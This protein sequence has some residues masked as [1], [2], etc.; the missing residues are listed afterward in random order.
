MNRPDLF[1]IW[2]TGLVPRISSPRSRPLD[3]DGSDLKSSSL[4]LITPRQVMSVS[5]VDEHVNPLL[6]FATSPSIE[7][8]R[9]SVGPQV[10]PDGP[11]TPSLM[12]SLRLIEKLKNSTPIT[13]ANDESMKDAPMHGALESE[14]GPIDASELFKAVMSDDLLTLEVLYHQQHVQSSFSVSLFLWRRFCRL[15]ATCMP[16]TKPG[17]L[18]SSWPSSAGGI[19]PSTH[20]IFECTT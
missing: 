7:M 8:S 2:R 14:Q 19:Q 4:S 1:G 12:R 9:Q 16:P 18:Y 5:N 11:S 13:E 6:G 10:Q 3:P 20:L 15:V 17:S